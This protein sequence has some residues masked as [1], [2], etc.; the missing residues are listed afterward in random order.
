[1]KAV[2]YARFSSEN[3]NENSITAQLRA[4]REYAKK[5]GVSIVR[6]YIDEAKSATTDDRPE[7][8]RMIAEITTGIVKV[9]LVFV[10]K[11]DRF[12][13]NR[14]DA[15]VYRHQ[16]GQKGARLVAVDQPLDDSPESVILESLLE[17]MAEYY[18]KNL[19]REIKKVKK[20]N[21]LQGL[22]RGG[23]PP[24]G[25]DVD[26]ITKKYI[27]N[28]IEA[29]IVRKIFAL[30]ADNQSLGS[31]VEKLNAMGY[32]TKRGQ[33]FGKNSIHDLLR[34]P[35]YFGQYIANR[36]SNEAEITVAGA[37]PAIVEPNLWEEVQKLMNERKHVV[38]RTKKREFLLTGKIFCA[39]C[40]AAYVG[41][42]TAVNSSRGKQPYPHYTCVNRKQNKTCDNRNIH[43]DTVETFILEKVEELFRRENIEKI[44][45]EFLASYAENI[46]G[47]QAKLNHAKKQLIDIQKRIDKLFDAIETDTMPAAVAGPR[48]TALTDEKAQLEQTISDLEKNIPLPFSTDQI[49]EYFLTNYKTI[50]Q[51]DK[52][53]WKRRIINA[54]VDKI[55]I[56]GEDISYTLKINP[57][58]PDSPGGK[59]TDVV[60]SPNG[61]RTRVSAVRGRCPRPLDDRTTLKKV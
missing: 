11:F 29:E 14:Y 49:R 2:A 47:T 19:S 37:I 58:P 40:G 16:L 34:N 38:P 3:Q 42:T 48:V 53:D 31:M 21:A 32:K 15:A 50:F 59:D 39:K 35:K 30:A 45:D 8:L 60:G 25:Y 61:I 51:K 46:K 5:N 33:P 44:V 10:H 9:D 12:A 28:P 18:S 23:T 24:L 55:F 43:Q 26:P 52:P 6:D 22:H 36:F 54:Y 56:D 20:E 17:G 27:I 1:M 57:N 41:N 13:R 7:F 4:I